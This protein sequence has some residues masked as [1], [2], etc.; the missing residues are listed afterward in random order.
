VPIFS[1]FEGNTIWIL[2]GLS[3]ALTAMVAAFRSLQRVGRKR[4]VL[5]ARSTAIAEAREG[6]LVM[7]RGTVRDRS[8]LQESPHR[9][10][11]VAELRVRAPIT[12]RDVFWTRVIVRGEVARPG[13]LSFSTLH[14]EVRAQTFVVED[15]S[16]KIELTLEGAH[17]VVA[18]ER[19]D[20][21][22]TQQ[23]DPFEPRLLAFFGQHIELGVVEADKARVAIR[24]FEEVILPGDEVS[25]VGIARRDPD[26][27]RIAPS[28]DGLYVVHGDARALAANGGLWKDA[29][30]V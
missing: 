16:G 12:G 1:L 20:R 25:I 14:R 4:R 24:T 28:P 22:F 9:T 15:A 6:E 5:S 11:P 23:G 27:V 7:V 19:V 29:P 26:G 10:P 2:A 3:I 21:T 8:G 30:D 13:M 17:V 18:P